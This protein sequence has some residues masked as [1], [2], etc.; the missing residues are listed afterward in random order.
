MVR[1]L[2]TNKHGGRFSQVCLDRN[3][4]FVSLARAYGFQGEKIADDSEV[5]GALERLA[6]GDGPYLLECLIDPMENPSKHR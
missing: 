5:R 1:E 6:A 3:P 4:D 2:Q